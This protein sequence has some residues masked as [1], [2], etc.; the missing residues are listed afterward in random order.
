VDQYYPDLTHPAMETALALVHSRFSTNTFPSWA[1]SHPYRYMAHNGEINTLRGNINWMHARL[2][3]FESEL[4]GEDI[5]KILPVINTDGSDSAMFDNCLEMLV[6][7]GRPLPHAVMMMIPEP[8]ENHES[9]SPEKHAFINERPVRKTGNVKALA[10]LDLARVTDGILD[11]LADDVKFAFERHVI[12]N[13]CTASDEH[14]PHERFRNFGRVTQRRIA[15]GNGTPSQDPLTFL[16]HDAFKDPLAFGALGGVRRQIEHADAVLAEG[17][18]G[19]LGFGTDELQELV[20]RLHQDAGAVTRVGFATTGAAMIEVEQNL[21][22]VAHD[23]VRLLPF[24]IDQKA[25]PTGVMLELGIVKP[26]LG[27]RQSASPLRVHGA[28]L[29]FSLFAH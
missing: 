29:P 9:M 21:Q 25:D 10:A 3:M 14:L 15:G 22:R 1:R 7:T 27:R 20:R 24:D 2:A 5:K 28:A 6:M 8:W 23:A 18:Q 11:A 17:G 13:L 26:L 4:F 16:G 19:N 12:G